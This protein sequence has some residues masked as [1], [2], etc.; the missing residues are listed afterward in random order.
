MAKK[1]RLHDGLETPRLP[2]PPLAFTAVGF[3]VFLAIAI[4]GLWTVFATAVPNRV[5]LPAHLPPQPR[6][7]AHPAVELST[8]VA[9]QRAR[10]SGYRWIDRDRKIAAIPIDRAMAIIAARGSE[11]YAPIPGAPPAPAPQIPD[12]LQN[13]THPQPPKAESPR[14]APTSQPP[15]AEP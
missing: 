9:Q 13:L 6:L 15:E 2:G 10:L 3:L 5:P 14:P 4:G 8:V 12:L 7:L 1:P 11:A